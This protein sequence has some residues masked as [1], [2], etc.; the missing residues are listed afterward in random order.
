MHI[1]Y[2]CCV[3]TNG[4]RHKY[5]QRVW[6]EWFLVLVFTFIFHFSMCTD[7]HHWW[8]M[9]HEHLLCSVTVRTKVLCARFLSISHVFF[10][11]NWVWFSF[12]PVSFCFVY[13]LIAYFPVAPYV[14]ITLLNLYKLHVISSVNGNFVCRYAFSFGWR[15]NPELFFWCLAIFFRLFCLIVDERSRRWIFC[16]LFSCIKN[17]IGTIESKKSC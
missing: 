14:R 12:F 15:V 9:R 10:P 16:L 11:F 8:K 3:H 17:R 4:H 5:I 13:V 6:F 2:C 1:R 7:R